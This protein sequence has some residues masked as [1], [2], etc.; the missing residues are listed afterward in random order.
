MSGTLGWVEGC[1][2]VSYL[3]RAVAKYEVSNRWSQPQRGDR[4]SGAVG[5][6][7]GTDVG[8]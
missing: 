8:H 6:R 2:F 7:G 1:A 4:R 3:S 5:V